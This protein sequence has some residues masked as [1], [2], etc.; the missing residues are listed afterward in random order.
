VI[1]QTLD[2]DHAAMFNSQALS[3]CRTTLLEG[4]P[5]PCRPASVVAFSPAGGYNLGL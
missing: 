5:A 3:I 1:E 2:L 4:R